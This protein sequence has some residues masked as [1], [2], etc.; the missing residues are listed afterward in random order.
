M[1]K[2]VVGTFDSRTEAEQVAELLM[3]RGFERGDIDI[4]ASG[5]TTGAPTSASH[6]STSWWEWL[7][8]ESEDRSYYSDRMNQGGAILA[9]T[10]D[11]GDAERARRLMEAEGGDV[12]ESQ[13]ADAGPAQT[14]G[15]G[16]PYRQPGAGQQGAEEVL[17]IVEERLR[18][19]KRP[20]A[21]GAVRVYSRVTE[22][23]VEE[24]VPLREE[25]VRVERRP[26][27]R[28][29]GDAAAAFREDV[30]EIQETAEE[31]VVAKE[32]RVVEEVIVAKDVEERVEQVSDRVRRTEIDV[33]RD[34]GG[35]G[36]PDA[37]GTDA[38]DFRRH[39][40]E[41]GQAA[42]LSQ[43]LSEPAY[44][45]GHELAGNGQEWSAIEPEARRRW[46][47][48]H[49]GTWERIVDSIRYAW[50]QTRRRRRAA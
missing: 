40:A 20:V 12:A 30:I 14:V 26:A 10:A 7:F 22:R 6:D 34:Q 3:G 2:T 24:R 8:G 48:R 47:E 28:P 16:S 42:G 1:R 35:T 36:G 4:R 41:R 25:H 13:S 17:P 50:E 31:V 46:E 38:A 18:I 9:V 19:G 49:P 5:M 39:W 33:E 27:D 32:A 21:S 23:P 15:Q 44:R 45:F 37:A 11:E 43:E 29:A